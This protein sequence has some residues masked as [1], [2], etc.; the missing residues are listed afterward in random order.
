MT[1]ASARARPRACT[2]R[3]RAPARAAPGA[4]DPA[5]RCT[6]PGTSRRRRRTPRGPGARWSGRPGR[7]DRRTAAAAAACRRP[8]ASRRRLPR[9]SPAAPAAAAARP[10]SRA[11]RRGGGRDALGERM[12]GVDD[13]ARCLLEQPAREASGRRSRPRA[14]RPRAAA[15]GR[16]GRPATRS[17]ARRRAR[18]PQRGRAPRRCRPGG[19]RAAAS[20]RGR[21][22]ARR[23]VEVAVAEAGGSQRLA[24]HDDR[25]SAH[26]GLR[27]AAAIVPSVPARICSS[28]QLARAT[29]TAGQSRAVVRRERR[30]D[31]VDGL[32]PPGAARASCRA[33]PAT[34]APPPPA[35]P[36]TG[37][38]GASGSPSG[39]LRAG[40]ARAAAPPPRQRTPARPASRPTGCRARPG[41]GS[42]RRARCRSRDRRS[43]GARRR[44]RASC[45]ARSSSTIS[46]SERCCVSTSRAPAGAWPSTSSGTSEPA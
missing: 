3:G 25:G 40:S 37:A 10:A 38:N 19:A 6:A 35:S 15:G 4:A 16:R 34:P 42:A 5:G 22:V 29:T 27:T 43:A 39:R 17:R 7:R 18:A 1:I 14:P 23:R 30:G 24:H 46:S 32:R 20:R 8:G 31:L 45:A 11:G 21:P 33:P 28:G 12:R 26:P 13:G 44:R 36:S 9:S 41:G 2:G